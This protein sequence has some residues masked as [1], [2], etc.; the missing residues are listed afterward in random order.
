[1][2]SQARS[3]D[4]LVAVARYERIAVNYRAPVSILAHPETF[5]WSLTNTTRHVG[6]AT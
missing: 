4:S 6:P 5:W 3:S 1:M 2:G